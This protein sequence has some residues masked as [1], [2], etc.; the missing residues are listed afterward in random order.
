MSSGTVFRLLAGCLLLP[1]SG[2]AQDGCGQREP[3]VGLL[4]QAPW[5][6]T[7]RQDAG[8]VILQVE[9]SRA[10]FDSAHIAGAQFVALGDFT[11]KQGE[12]LTELPPLAQLDSLLESLGI[13]EHGR[14]VLY[15]DF[16]PVTRLFFTLDYLGLGDRVSLLDGGITAWRELNGAT[17]AL[18][19]PPATRTRLSLHPLAN[20]LADAAWVEAHRSDPR[21]ALLDARSREEFEGTKLEEGVARPGHIPGAQ[22]LEWS[23]LLTEGRLRARSDLQQLFAGAGATPGKELITYC[24]VG[25]RASALYFVGRLLGYP[26]RLYDGSMND[27]ASRKELP[28][29]GPTR[30]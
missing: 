26:V 4:L 6:K 15:G 2:Q 12:L 29:V 16:L 24:R 11:T 17:T 13:G 7:H 9:R 23:T 28:V 8:L 21:V 25:T 30:P 14:I 1:A 18:P 5:L 10:P 19:T 20:V 3:A 22:N 27:W